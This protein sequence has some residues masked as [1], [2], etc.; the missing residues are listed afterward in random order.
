VVRDQHDL[1]FVEQTDAEPLK[2]RLDPTRTAGIVDHC[3]V[4]L[5]RHHLARRDRRA[6][7]GAGDDLFGKR[8]R[9]GHGHIPR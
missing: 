7:G 6:A 8:H 2:D 4:D 3:E 9:A 5:R 1:L